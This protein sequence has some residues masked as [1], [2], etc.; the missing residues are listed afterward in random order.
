MYPNVKNFCCRA[1]GKIV[2]ANIDDF[3]ALKEHGEL[4][5]SA[6]NTGSVPSQFSLAIN[7]TAGVSSIPAREFSLDPGASEQFQFVVRVESEE[8]RVH[9]CTVTLFDAIFDRVDTVHVNVTARGLEKDKG[10]QEGD[11]PD[12]E[13]E[14][15]SDSGSSDCTDVCGL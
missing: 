5:V 10:A 15:E 11:N 14:Y 8:E 6:Q 13:D 1:T 9:W 7:C 3:E 2:K 12:R 4:E